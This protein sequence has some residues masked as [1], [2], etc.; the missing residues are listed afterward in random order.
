MEIFE[1]EVQVSI[2]RT[3]R[4]YIR[5]KCT[6]ALVIVSCRTINRNILFRAEIADNRP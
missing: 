6:K 1:S 4:Q 2:I 5:N 3:F